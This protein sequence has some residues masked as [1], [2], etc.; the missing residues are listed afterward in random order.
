MGANPKYRDHEGNTA[1]TEAC[2]MGSYEIA[3]YMLELKNELKIDVNYINHR[4]RTALHKAAFNGHHQIVLIL[5]EN[6]ADPRMNDS[7]LG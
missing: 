6:G 7:A 1:F 4:Q 3:S 5:L 2:L